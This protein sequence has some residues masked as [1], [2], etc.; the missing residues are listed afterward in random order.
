MFVVSLKFTH[1]RGEAPPFMDA[2]VQWIRRGIDD[3]VFLLAGRLE[4]QLGGAVL[5]Q[6]LSRDELQSRLQQDPFVSEGIV[7]VEI[8]EIT[9]SKADP[10]LAFVS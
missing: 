6:G 5:A 7:S 8:V 9:P 10:R 3:G 4:P 1:R 2:H